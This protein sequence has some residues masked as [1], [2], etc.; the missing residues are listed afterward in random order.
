MEQTLAMAL[1]TVKATGSRF[2]LVAIITVTQTTNNR[3]VNGRTNTV[4][5]AFWPH[6]THRRG[7]KAFEEIPQPLQGTLQTKGPAR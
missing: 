4:E 7:A 1:S 6:G 2:A 3:F 5:F